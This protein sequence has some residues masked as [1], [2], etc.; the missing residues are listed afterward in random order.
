MRV[1]ELLH[2]EQLDT[3]APGCEREALLSARSA[4]YV[5]HQDITYSYD[6]PIRD[7][8]QRLVVM[9]RRLHCDQRRV[10]QRFSISSSAAH[11][12]RRRIDRFG[13]V[14]VNV[15]A[16]AVDSLVEFRMRA[17]LVRELDR[18]AQP[19]WTGT[20][21]HE[22]RLTRP[23]E[24]LRDAARPF[25]SDDAIGSAEAVSAF[26][27]SSMAYRHDVTGVR[28]TAAEAWTLRQG[29][30]QDMA[31]VTIAMCASIGIS[32]RYVSGHMVGDG[33]SHAWIEVRDPR[34]ST[35]V[36]VDPTHD[37]RTDLRYVTTATGRD[38]LDVAPTAGTYI[39]KGARG[40][41][42]VRKTIRV[43]ELNA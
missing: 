38:Y 34:T 13:N 12:A 19:T 39:A 42:A 21:P 20:T 35:V 18:P 26:V 10:A 36:A 23:D 28:T 22:T 27:H 41:L 9:P 33:A 8:R 37:R 24:A 3:L 40:S 32:T 29:V 6:R 7:L 17:V 25:A 5:I 4:T 31:H 1:E 16:P 15:S 14:V 30:C 2:D 43:A 11:H